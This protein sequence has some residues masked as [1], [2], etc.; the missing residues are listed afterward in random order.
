ME[1]PKFEPDKVRE[2]YWNKCTNEQKIQL[3]ELDIKNLEDMIHH[4]SKSS[5]HSNPLKQ[6][7]FLN[8]L[9]ERIKLKE[10]QIK[11]LAK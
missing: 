10:S 8:S 11:K 7:A 5:V 6:T 9:K 1:K 3:L 4:Y 2:D